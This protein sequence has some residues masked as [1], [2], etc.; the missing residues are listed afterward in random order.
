MPEEWMDQ[1]YNQATMKE[2]T[3]KWWL[4]VERARLSV[5]LLDG[6]YRGADG[7]DMFAEKCYGHMGDRARSKSWLWARS[8]LQDDEFQAMGW[9]DPIVS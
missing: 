8:F 4:N 6:Q 5:E 3:A 2:F 9:T 7:Q 1:P